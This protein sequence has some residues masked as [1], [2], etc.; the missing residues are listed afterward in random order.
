VLGTLPSGRKIFIE[1]K[2]GP[3]ILPRLIWD[4]EHSPVD[5]SQVVVIA[6]EQEVISTIKRRYPFVSA[7]WIVEIKG[8]FWGGP[9]PGAAGL[10]DKLIDLKAD[11]L[12]T[13]ASPR[14]NH[15]FIRTL[16]EAGLAYNVWTID[17]P[18]KAARFISLGATS[19]T[20]NCPGRV[21]KKLGLDAPV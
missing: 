13:N 17:S 1:V 7:L 9:R 4:I 5:F 3:E 14:I 21:I 15:K 12:S 18:R 8:T 6:Y 16:R 19:I 11:G 20:T 10:L 2:C